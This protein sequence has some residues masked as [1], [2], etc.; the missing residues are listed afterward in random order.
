MLLLKGHFV[1]M[2]WKI[3]SSVLGN[4]QNQSLDSDLTV[5]KLDMLQVKPQLLARSPAAT[6]AGERTSN[7]VV[8]TADEQTQAA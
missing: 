5:T 7:L 2:A 6:A 8:L 1:Y 3:S 4:G